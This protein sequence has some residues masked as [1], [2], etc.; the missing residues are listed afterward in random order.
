MIT[1]FNRIESG[2]QTSVSSFVNVAVNTI[3]DGRFLVWIKEK[4][5]ERQEQFVKQKD[6]EMEVIPKLR[7]VFEDS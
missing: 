4:I 1:S 7:S 6:L 3:T 2:W 5:K